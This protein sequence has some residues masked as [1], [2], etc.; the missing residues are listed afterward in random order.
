MF[1]IGNTIVSEKQFTCPVCGTR[2]HASYYGSGNRTERC[3]ECGADLV[4]DWDRSGCKV[5]T[6]FLRSGMHEPTLQ[7][8]NSDPITS[9]H[10]SKIIR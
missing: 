9:R 1:G 3:D 5:S 8:C 4:F 2:F 7:M 10:G 6:G